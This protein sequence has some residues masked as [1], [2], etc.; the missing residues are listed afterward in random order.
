MSLILAS[1]LTSGVVYA[2]DAQVDL[3]KEL[4]A[5]KAELNEL[6]ATVKNSNFDGMQREL[7]AIKKATY[8]DNLKFSADYR[9]TIDSI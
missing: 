5:L 9:Y 8:G 7:S 6:K 1:L 4:E 2:A 3:A